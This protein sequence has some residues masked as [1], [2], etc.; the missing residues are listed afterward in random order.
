MAEQ[1]Q[2][3]LWLK[4]CLAIAAVLVAGAIVCLILN[5]VGWQDIGMEYFGALGAVG[6]VLAVISLVVDV[7]KRKHAAA[8]DL[9][10]P[11]AGVYVGGDNNGQIITGSV[12]GNVS[13]RH[14][15]HD[16]HNVTNTVNITNRY[17]HGP[18]H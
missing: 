12:S 18:T 9:P 7:N 2:M 4:C 8:D 16:S 5:R 1:R 17:D 3:P 11:A 15:T 10:G 14:D 6:V 13:D